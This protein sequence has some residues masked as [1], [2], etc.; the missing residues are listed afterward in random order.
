MSYRQ[1]EPALRD[2]NEAIRLNPSFALAYS[3]R[4]SAYSGLQQYELAVQDYSQ[5]IRLRPRNV[6]FDQKRA[7]AFAGIRRLFCWLAP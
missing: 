1:Y 3:N 6:V 2:F 5:A 7:D 4:G